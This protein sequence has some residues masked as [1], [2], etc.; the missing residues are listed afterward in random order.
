MDDM[1]G[2]SP[3]TVMNDVTVERTYSNADTDEANLDQYLTNVLSLEAVACKDWL[4]NKVD[5]S[6][7][8]KIARQQC[9]GEIQLPLSDCG[10]VALDYNADA[11]ASPPQSDTLRRPLWPTPRPV[12][13]WLWPNRS[14]IS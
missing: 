2:N 3:K 1:F 4:T 14:P 5:R 9:Q 12:R 13:Y 11:P 8:G 10:A 6:V 7:T